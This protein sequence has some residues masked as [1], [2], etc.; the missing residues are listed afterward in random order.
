MQQSHKY[1][2]GT[3]AFWVAYEEDLERTERMRLGVEGPVD[4][5]NRFA[6][7]TNVLGRY[8]RL[9]HSKHRQVPERLII[10]NVSHYDTVTTFFKNHVANIPQEVHVPV[11]YDGGMSLLVDPAGGVSITIQGVVYPVEFSQRGAVPARVR[12]EKDTS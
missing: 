12:R 10:W 1:G 9:F 5:S 4:M 3:R 11:D 7:F 6:R 2:E 8:A